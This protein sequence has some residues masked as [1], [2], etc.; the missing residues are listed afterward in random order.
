MSQLLW[1][2]ARAGLGQDRAKG[3]AGHI[4]VMRDWTW[5]RTAKY[6]LAILG[7]LEMRSEQSRGRAR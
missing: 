6:V 1:S 7:Q 5:V 4:V 2:A 3:R